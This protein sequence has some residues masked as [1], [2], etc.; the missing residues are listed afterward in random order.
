MGSLVA[1]GGWQESTALFK[2]LFSP[3]IKQHFVDNY[4][5]LQLSLHKT[6][7]GAAGSLQRIHLVVLFSICSVQ[8]RIKSQWLSVV[9]NPLGKLAMNI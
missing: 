3:N 9:V 6:Q 7:F 2:V 1:G 4:C 8:Y 5:S